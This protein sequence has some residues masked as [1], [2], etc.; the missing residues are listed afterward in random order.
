MES[1]LTFCIF[2]L[3][4]LIQSL[5]NFLFSQKY[6]ENE[7]I[8][9]K[10]ELKNK[11]EDCE[12]LKIEVMDLKKVIQLNNINQ[13]N[14]VHMKTV[15]R[16]NKSKFASKK[17]SELRTHSNTNHQKYEPLTCQICDLICETKEGLSF[18]IKMEHVNSD[19]EPEKEFNCNECCFQAT[20]QRHLKK[21]FELVHTQKNN[22]KCIRCDFSGITSTELSEHIEAIHV[23]KELKCNICPFEGTSITNLRTH[24]MKEH[25]MKDVFRCRICGEVFELYR[26]L[27]EHR[28]NEHIKTVAYCRNNLKGS[29]L[30][31]NEKCWW[32]HDTQSDSEKRDESFK[33]YIC[34]STFQQKGQMMAHK[35]S[36]HPESV[37]YCNLFLDS[38]CIFNDNACWYRHTV[39]PKKNVEDE[40]SVSEKSVF[41]E[42][43]ENLKPPI[44]IQETERNQNAQK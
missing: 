31:S 38:K 43:Q 40:N 17:E 19:I 29:C 42:V 25:P 3:K 18:H 35:K 32:N 16:E 9:C 11:T 22:F 1:Q 33:C 23:S 36:Q 41:Q 20:E 14:D 2:D 4:D 6:I 37:R 10:E 44:K 21:H 24:S 34:D 7:F 13:L 28:K 30:F 8:K 5:L 39:N 15:H 26:N 12:K 27:M